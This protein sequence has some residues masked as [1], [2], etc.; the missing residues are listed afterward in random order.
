M[1]RQEEL[2]YCSLVPKP[3]N[4]ASPTG[5]SMRLKLYSGNTWE[6]TGQSCLFRAS[7]NGYELLPR[8]CMH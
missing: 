5:L 1:F 4:E 2:F 8:T 6:L 7:A 3:G